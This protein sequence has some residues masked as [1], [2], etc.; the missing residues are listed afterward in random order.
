MDLQLKEGKDE[1]IP[2]GHFNLIWPVSEDD[3]T[4][5]EHQVSEGDRGDQSSAIKDVLVDDEHHSA[6]QLKLS[7][8]QSFS[9]VSH[10]IRIHST[11][12]AISLTGFSNGV[13]YA[14]LF[15]ADDQPVSNIVSVKV[16]HHSMFKVWVI[17]ISGA[18]LFLILIGYMVVKVFRHKEEA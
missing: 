18:T 10:T 11:Q 7:S 8:E 12:R 4:T 3:S 15:N 2:A 5:S 6:T 9:Q 14:Q 13:Y 17:F 1:V 16:E